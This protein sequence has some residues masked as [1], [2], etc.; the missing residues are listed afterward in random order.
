MSRHT[1]PVRSGQDRTNI[2]REITDEIISELEAD[3]IPW[4][5]PWG[6]ASATATIATPLIILA[7]LYARV[8]R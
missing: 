6:M 4:A 3:R 1:A 7:A 2:N 8:R 5:Q